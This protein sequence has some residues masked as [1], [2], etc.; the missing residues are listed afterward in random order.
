[1]GSRSVEALVER[2]DARRQEF[3]L[4]SANGPSSV[5]RRIHDLA[6]FHVVRH[7]KGMDTGAHFVRDQTH[8]LED[9]RGRLAPVD[10]RI[11]AGFLPTGNHRYPGSVHLGLWRATTGRIAWNGSR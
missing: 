4:G 9:I 11:G 10:I 7:Y 6:H 8:R 3:D 5:T 1:M 2:G